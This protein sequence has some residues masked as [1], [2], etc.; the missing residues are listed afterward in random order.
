MSIVH[1]TV[2]CPEKYSKV[3]LLLIVLTT[4]EKEREREREVNHGTR[5]DHPDGEEGRMSPGSLLC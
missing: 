2:L 5:C 1:N 4:R 3:D